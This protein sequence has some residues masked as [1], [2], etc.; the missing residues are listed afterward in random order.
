MDTKGPISSSSQNNSDIFVIFVAFSH[1]VVTNS[2]PH[3]SP[4]YAIQ[5]LLSHWGHLKTTFGPPQYLLT[6]PGT[7]YIDKDM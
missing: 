4:K 6:D 3:I 5:K 7:E 1:F 2:A